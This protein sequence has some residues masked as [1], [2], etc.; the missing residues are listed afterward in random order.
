[1]AFEPGHAEVGVEV[2]EVGDVEVA[3]LNPSLEGEG[4]GAGL[5]ADVV[6]VGGLEGEGEWARWARDGGEA[7]AGDELLGEEVAGGARV[8]EDVGGVV[9]DGGAEFEE[10]RARGVGGPEMACRSLGRRVRGRS[11]GDGVGDGRDGGGGSGVGRGGR[12]GVGDGG[13]SNVSSPAYWRPRPFPDSARKRG[14]SRL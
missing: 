1:V 10:L 4:G 12:G 8:D 6:G 5:V 7:V 9:G 11:V 14:Q 2:V 3:A 13:E